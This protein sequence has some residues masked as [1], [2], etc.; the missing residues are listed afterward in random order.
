[1][2]KPPEPVIGREIWPLFDYCEEHLEGPFDDALNGNITAES[3]VKLLPHMEHMVELIDRALTERETSGY[4]RDQF[5]Q[6]KASL[7]TMIANFRSAL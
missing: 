2:T 7:I 1:M 6:M 5:V 4:P 3:A